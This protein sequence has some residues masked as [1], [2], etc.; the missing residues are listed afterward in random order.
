MQ[1]SSFFS[2]VFE[3]TDSNNSQIIGRIGDYRLTKE[4]GA[5]FSS[6][7]MLAHKEGTNQQFALKIFKLEGEDDELRN[8]LE[9]LRR[10]A[11][12]M[13]NLNH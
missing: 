7:V 12:V 8:N 1:K 2:T 9:L 13:Q 6:K 4:L 5:G 3:N 10:E 11:D